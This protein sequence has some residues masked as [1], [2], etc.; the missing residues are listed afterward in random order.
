[1]HILTT[2]P[3]FVLI[4][5]LWEVLT[6]P[7]PLLPIQNN[8]TQGYSK[9]NTSNLFSIIVYMIWSHI[10]PTKMP[11]YVYYINHHSYTCI[12]LPQIECGKVIYWMVWMRFLMMRY[13]SD[14]FYR[15]YF[16]NQQLWIRLFCCH[17]WYKRNFPIIS[18][19]KTTF[20]PQIQ[21]EK[22]TYKCVEWH[23]E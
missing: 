13:L 16:I 18:P 1:M 20:L 3:R 10:T 4:W 6:H 8:L 12:I 2:I 15:Y 11:Q 23:W 9:A 21:R 17:T 5:L 7:P 22:G 14:I 19:F